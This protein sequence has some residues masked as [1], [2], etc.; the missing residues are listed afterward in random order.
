MPPKTESKNEKLLQ[1]LFS[2]KEGKKYFGKHVV[3]IGGKAT[4]LPSN[5]EKATKLIEK[6]EDK[7]P[8]EIPQL[9]FIP[10]PET[11]ILIYG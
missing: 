11:Y 5:R 10:R 1:T 8:G 2:G 9:A 3:I 7:Y 4:I 6:L